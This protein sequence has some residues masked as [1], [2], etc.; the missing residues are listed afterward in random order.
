[1]FDCHLWC[2]FS[3]ISLVWSSGSELELDLVV[4]P[5]LVV[6]LLKILDQAAIWS[7]VGAR[8]LLLDAL[9]RLSRS[10]EMRLVNLPT[11]SK[12]SYLV[13]CLFP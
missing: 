3:S 9:A 12:A 7:L 1:M 8:I 11:S 13:N 5:P 4:L 10:P 2:R 6:S